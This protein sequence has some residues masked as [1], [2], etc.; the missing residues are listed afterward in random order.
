MHVATAVAERF[1][2]ARAPRERVKAMVLRRGA[3]G[4]E[5]HEEVAQ[6]RH[7]AV[8]T[9]GRLTTR[10]HL[11]PELVCRAFDI[12]H[13]SYIDYNKYLRTQLGSLY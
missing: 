10:H 11:Q 13:K 12:M 4:C 9:A 6:G 8:R 7:P 2:R 1:T 3:V 5:E